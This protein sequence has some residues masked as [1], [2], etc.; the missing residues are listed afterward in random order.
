MKKGKKIITAALAG[1]MCAA[2]PVAAQAES[3]AVTN[4][5]LYESAEPVYTVTVP[6]TIEV[7]ARGNTDVTVT[8]E[9]MKNIP[10]DK[11]I[12]VTLEKGNGVYGRLYLT[13][14]NPENPDG[15]QLTLTLYVTG[16]DGEPKMGALEHQIKGMELAA[17]TENG[18]Q[19]YR[20]S[21]APSL[22]PVKGAEYSGYIV[23]GIEMKDK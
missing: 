3:P 2:F 15:K 9:D 1:A 4:L 23:Y 16:T 21:V 5:T 8:A 18:S 6:E 12:S 17:F 20:L 19:D 14:Q 11:K 10:D 7:A 22:T 13:A